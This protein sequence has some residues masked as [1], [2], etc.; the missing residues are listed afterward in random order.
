MSALVFFGLGIYEIIV[1][2]VLLG[3]PLLRFFGRLIF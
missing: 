3:G 1:L 2:L